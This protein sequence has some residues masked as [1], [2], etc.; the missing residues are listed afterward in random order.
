VSIVTTFVI[1]RLTQ[2]KDLRQAVETDVPA[3]PLT[4]GGMTAA[5]GIAATATALLMASTLDT[6]L[7]PPTAGAGLATALVVLAMERKAPWAILRRV[8]WGV[9]PLVAGL[10]VLV[11]ALDKSGVINTI[12]TLLRDEA[13]RSTSAAA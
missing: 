4:R 1:L 5:L 12:A 11:E 3:V 13:Q 6:Q 10:F 8:S 7:G 9:L 2:R